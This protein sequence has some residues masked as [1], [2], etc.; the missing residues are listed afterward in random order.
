MNTDLQQKVNGYETQFKEQ[1]REIDQVE[2]EKRRQLQD[3]SSK[4]A[5]LN[6]ALEELE[7]YK[8]QLRE[9]RM[10]EQG[11]SDNVRRDM[12][13]LVNDNRKLERERNELLQAF[14][15]QMKLIDVLKR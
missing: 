4:D 14:K 13:K 5:K 3:V 12:E 11:K 1:N 2:R 9:A 10:T 8:Q 7:K 15:K 6:R